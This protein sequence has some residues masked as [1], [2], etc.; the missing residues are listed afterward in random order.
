MIQPS[1]QAIVSWLRQAISLYSNGE[2]GKAATLCNMILTKQPNNFDALYLIGIIYLEQGKTKSAIDYISSAAG[3]N[4]NHARLLVALGDAF[5][6]MEQYEDAVASYERAIKNNPDLAEA[7]NNCGTALENLHR[8]ENALTKYEQS[9]KINPS[10]A[11]AHCNKGNVLRSLHRLGEAL[12]SY[13]RAVQLKPDYLCALNNYGNALMLLNRHEEAADVFSKLMSLAPEYDYAVGNLFHSQLHCCNWSNYTQ[14]LE[15]IIQLTQKG[16]PVSLPFAFLAISNSPSD[17][18]KC[19]QTHINNKYPLSPSPLSSGK[20]YKHGKIRLAYI[21]ADFREHAVSYL[22]VG[23]FE[24]HDKDKF[25]TIAISLCPEENS[26]TRQ[27]VKIAFSQFIDASQM[28]DAEIAQLLRTMEVDIAIDLLGFTQG[29]RTKVFSSR[30]APIQVNFLGYPGTMGASY[31]DYIIADGLVIPPDHQKYYIEK[32]VYI[33]NTYQVNDSTRVIAE[34]TT[35]REDAMLPKTGFVFCCFNSNYKISP[36]IFDTWMRL[37]IKV[38][39][40]VLWLMECS[41][42]ARLNLKREAV[43]RGIETKRLI[44]APKMKHDEHLARQRLADLFLD[45]LPYNAHTT[46]SDALLAG[47]PILTCTGNTFAGRVATSLL[48]AVGLPELITKDLQEYEELAFKL[49]TTP[50]LISAIKVKLSQNLNSFPLFDTG[51]FCTH[52][53]SA[54][55]TMLQRYQQGELPMSFKVSL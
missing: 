49:A 24:K 13:E 11:V 50:D 40:S 17:Q 31:V 5:A 48:S 39:G 15:K 19:A 30:S 10:F 25:E 42:T 32:V 38:D 8:Y 43:V 33:P 28:N 34:Q 51:L 22:M 14:I 20:R 55:V 27:R 18:L 16:K 45:T 35:S 54:Y 23:L 21:S 41:A 37:L 2:M 3:I 46:A 52:I 47:L 44:F 6:E 4:G 26:P 36:D 9:I 7:F 12:A 53:E 1:N 29:H